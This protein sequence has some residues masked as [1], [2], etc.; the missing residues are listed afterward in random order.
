MRNGFVIAQ[1]IPLPVVLPAVGKAEEQ[2]EAAP[3]RQAVAAIES[4]VPFADERRRV[5]RV[6]EV[7]AKGLFGQIDP[8]QPTVARHVDR[9]RAVI[10][11]PGEIPGP[12]RRA[13][14]RRRVMRREPHA[15]LCKCIQHRR[16]DD[17]IAIA[18]QVTPAEI[19][20]KDKNDI[21]L[22]QVGAL[23]LGQ[24][25]EQQGGKD[26]ENTF[27]GVISWLITSDLLR[28]SRQSQT[29]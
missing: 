12:R 10:E 24:R 23:K 2:I 4:V 3:M 28:L 26:D 6:L 20:G 9:A 8:V 21:G 19:I 18:T 17:R 27:H 5:A 15:V 25:R 14:G 7:V 16:V 29:A 22:R 1:E 11:S 13:Q